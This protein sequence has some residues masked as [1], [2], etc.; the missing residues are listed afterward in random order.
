MGEAGKGCWQSLQRDSHRIMPMDHQDLLRHMQRYVANVAITSVFRNK[1]LKGGGFVA[2]ARQH[3]ADINLKPLANLDPSEYPKWLEDRT[4]ELAANLPVKLWSPARKAINIFMVMAS[5]NRFLYEEYML[6][7]FKYALE[8]PLDNVV[9]KKLRRFGRKQKLFA[10]KEFP[11]WRSIYALDSINNEK[12]QQIAKSY[13]KELGIP[14]G[15]LDVVLWEPP[16][17]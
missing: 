1:N 4:R 12:Y 13:A 11:K 10:G 5:L 6:G 3:L 14:R 17:G 16:K 15:E 2:A 8:V 9:E 7:R